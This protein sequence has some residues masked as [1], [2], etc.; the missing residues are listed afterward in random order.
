MI[1]LKDYMTVTN[2][3]I[4]EGSDYGWQCYGSHAYQLSSWNGDHDGWSADVVFDTQTQTVYEMGVCDY[5]RNRA[6]RW[7]NPDFADAYQDEAASRDV[8]HD[9]AWDDVNYVNLELAE[10]ILEKAQAIVNGREYD[11]RISVPIELPDET[12]LELFKAAHQADM[13]LNEFVTELLRKN[14]I[15]HHEDSN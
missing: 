4:T 6:Y 5:S 3:R 2:Y 13:T 10:D 14:I 1:T 12:M 7:M 11:T 9:Q 8:D 15:K